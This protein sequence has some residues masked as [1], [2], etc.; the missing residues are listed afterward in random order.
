MSQ[1]N[2]N[3]ITIIYKINEEKSIKLFGD[4][5]VNNNK[6][7]CQIFIDNEYKDILK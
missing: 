5:F 4:N 6:G 1:T 7:N 2:L 3:E